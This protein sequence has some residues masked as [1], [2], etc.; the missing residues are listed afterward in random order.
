MLN[1][2]NNHLNIRNKGVSEYLSN[3]YINFPF[4]FKKWHGILFEK[5]RIEER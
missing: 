1:I 4:S 3:I 2:G 5:I